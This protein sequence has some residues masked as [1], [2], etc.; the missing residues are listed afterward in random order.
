MRD[1]NQVEEAQDGVAEERQAQEDLLG[2]DDANGS[3][4]DEVELAVGRPRRK[5]RRPN[6][7]GDWEYVREEENE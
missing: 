4:E 6:R 5:H 1:R 2:G 3:S 7:Y